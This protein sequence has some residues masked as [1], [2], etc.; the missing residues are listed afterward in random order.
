M[1]KPQG[2]SNLLSAFWTL[3]SQVHTSAF[4]VGTWFMPCSEHFIYW[5]RQ[6]RGRGG[7]PVWCLWTEEWE[8][9]QHTSE[10]VWRPE[11]QG[12]QWYKFCLVEDL[13]TSISGIQGEKKWISGLKLREQSPTSSSLFQSQLLTKRTR[14]VPIV[15]EIIT[16]IYY[17]SAS[18]H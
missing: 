14:P 8:N 13:R 10:L 15:R 6:R 18:K 2:Y 12:R 7:P 17:R 5:Q 3:R 1:E 4:H 16:F 9:Q 11:D